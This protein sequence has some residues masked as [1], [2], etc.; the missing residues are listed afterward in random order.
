MI[1][2]SD[3]TNHMFPHTKFLK[4]LRELQSPQYVGLGD[5]KMKLEIVARGTNHLVGDGLLVPNLQYGLI[6]V[7]QL[8]KSELSEPILNTRTNMVIEGR[9][10]IDKS[11][12]TY[13]NSK[14]FEFN[15]TNY[16]IIDKEDKSLNENYGGL[17][18]KT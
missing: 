17:L 12:R 13:K 1:I 6:S 10:H 18:D 2:D 11:L 14:Q 5:P 9:Q 7:P 15:K 3:A 8:N 4:N 16:I